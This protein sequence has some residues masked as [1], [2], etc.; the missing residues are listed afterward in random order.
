MERSVRTFRTGA[1]VAS[2]GDRH[3]A[4]AAVRHGYDRH[5]HSNRPGSDG[6]DCDDQRNAD[7]GRFE[8]GV[9][10]GHVLPVVR[11]GHVRVRGHAASPWFPA[12]TPERFKNSARQI[13]KETSPAVAVS[14]RRAV[15][16][17]G[18]RAPLTYRLTDA[19]VVPMASAKSACRLS[20]RCA[21]SASE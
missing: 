15:T 6:S 10:V 21:F 3:L 17:S 20:A 14:M 4:L 9:K 7:A 2:R 16:A 5:E 1:A 13:S 8:H 19:C 11:R 12:S 18:N